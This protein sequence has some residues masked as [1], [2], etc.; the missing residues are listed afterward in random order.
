M[1]YGRIDFESFL[2]FFAPFLRTHKAESSEVV[3]SV[4][5]LNDDNSYILRH[6]KK[7]F[8]YI[9]CLLLL[10]GAQR[11]LAHFC[12]AV[13][14]RGDFVAETLFNVFDCGVG[15]LNNIVQKCGYYRIFIH[16]VIR[17]YLRHGYG[18]NYIGLTRKAELPV[19]LFPRPVESLVY[20]FE[21]ALIHRLFKCLAK[22]YIF[23]IRRRSGV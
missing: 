4:S 13:Y 20:F 11:H 8:S 3:Y 14:Y 23:F 5:K 15:I 9:L 6:G 22:L 12:K 7:H 17:K 1:S 16:A 21:F 19:M 2:R 10:F 18:V